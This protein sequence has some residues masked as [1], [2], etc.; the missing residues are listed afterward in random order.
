MEKLSLETGAQKRINILNIFD[1]GDYR[2]MYLDE[3]GTELYSLY[4]AAKYFEPGTVLKYFIPGVKN[5][6]KIVLLNGDEQLA[7]KNISINTPQITL[8]SEPSLNDKNQLVFKYSAEDADGDALTYSI[9]QTLDNNWNKYEYLVQDHNETIY[10]V[11]PGELASGTYQFK[12]YVSD[13]VNTSYKKTGDII[14]P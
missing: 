11:E 3:N 6:R 7:E 9:Y 1:V 13:G 14:I 2:F 8:N 12:I 10:I 4:M 5:T